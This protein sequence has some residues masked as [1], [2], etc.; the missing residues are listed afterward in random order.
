MK[1]ELLRAKSV[2]EEGSEYRYRWGEECYGVSGL[3]VLIKPKNH[4][5]KEF[6]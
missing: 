6:S 2:D 4:F 3:E 1:E 5:K